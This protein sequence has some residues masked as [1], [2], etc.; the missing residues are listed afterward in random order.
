MAE[1]SYGVSHGANAAIATSSPTMATPPVRRR[2]LRP[3]ET[4]PLGEISATA[5]P[6]IDRAV[7]QIDGE[8]R[9]QHERRGEEH[10]AGDDRD[11]EAEDRLHGEP[12]EAGP[13]E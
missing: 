12:A 9:G 8:V 7:E 6:R 3:G 11:V 2:R 13:V 5:H 4:S 10:G 1:G